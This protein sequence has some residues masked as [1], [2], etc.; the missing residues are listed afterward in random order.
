MQAQVI[1]VSPIDTDKSSNTE[2]TAGNDSETP[3][4]D[5]EAVADRQ[6]SRSTRWRRYADET[7]LTPLRIIWNDWR[8][9][10]SLVLLSGY[11]LMGVIAVISKGVT[12]FGVTLKYV[13]VSRPRSGQGPYGELIGAFNFI[14]W[15]WLWT[16]QGPLLSQNEMY[17][18]FPLGTT[19]QGASILS[20]LVH[21]TPPMFKMLLAGAV[22]STGMATV[23]GTVAGYKGGRTDQMLMGFAD[24]M[25]ALPGLPLVI[26]LGAILQPRNPYIIGIIL[27]INA[28]A[29][30]SRSLRSQVLVL[31]EAEYVEA[32]RVIGLSTS[33]IISDDIIPN[34]MPYIAMNFVQQGRG[35]IFGSVALYFLGI[36]PQTDVVNWG[37]MMQKAYDRA[38]AVSS[39]E[40]FYWLA[41][42]MIAIILLG[43]SLTLLAQAADRLFNPRVR[44]RHAASIVEEEEESTTT[45]STGGI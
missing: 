39:P 30:L 20:Q 8:A 17:W 14:N 9:Q 15:E 13:I 3:V 19:F 6:L 11:L 37:M 10:V 26:I 44:A 42:P 29:G 12:V 31:R 1:L 24:I 34:I 5:F 41:I 33:T 25:M 27:T 23:V 21:A 2:S 36:L 38:G 43:L 22:F 7:V 45:S 18:Q 16:L 40:A 32:S 35:V 4:L 28:W